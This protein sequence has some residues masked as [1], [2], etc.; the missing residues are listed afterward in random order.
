MV[1]D[2]GTHEG[3][4]DDWHTMVGHDHAERVA[5]LVAPRAPEFPVEY[6]F[7]M[8]RTDPFGR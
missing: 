2:V 1:D 7:N 8:E 6:P 5:R 4:I 3:Q